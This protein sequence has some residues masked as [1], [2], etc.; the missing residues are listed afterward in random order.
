MLR[1][2]EKRYA[3]DTTC[4]SNPDSQREHRLN[5]PETVLTRLAVEFYV[6]IAVFARVPL[7][8]CEALKHC[9]CTPGRT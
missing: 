6:C 1:V 9:R 3:D 2:V 8:S 5:S 7:L 4:A